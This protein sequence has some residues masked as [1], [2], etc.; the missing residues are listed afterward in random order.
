MWSTGG[1]G[2]EVGTTADGLL[3]SR[4]GDKEVGLGKEEKVRI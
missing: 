2:R 4:R 1:G 3:Q